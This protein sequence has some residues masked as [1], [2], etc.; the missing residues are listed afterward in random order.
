M[1][2]QTSHD[3][4]ANFRPK[5]FRCPHTMSWSQALH[6]LSL[7]SSRSS[8][9]SETLTPYSNNH[10]LQF[11]LRMNS[12]LLTSYGDL[13]HLKDIREIDDATFNDFLLQ[14]FNKFTSNINAFFNDQSEYILTGHG[15][16]FNHS[17]INYFTY[18][19][20]DLVRHIF[21]FFDT[22]ECVDFCYTSKMVYAQCLSFIWKYISIPRHQPKF[23]NQVMI[24][25]RWSC[26]E[27][28]QQWW[29]HLD[30]TKSAKIELCCPKHSKCILLTASR[31][32]NLKELEVRL[33]DCSSQDWK[34]LVPTF[35][36]FLNS[37]SLTTLKLVF[38]G[39]VSQ[40]KTHSQGL[41]E[42]G[43]NCSR[44]P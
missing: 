4:A 2:S 37:L 38:A 21:G 40:L 15:Y 43:I 36:N 22:K 16:R 39:K 34:N 20:D 41:M 5:K 23:I 6:S 33:L 24:G 32:M 14:V 19:G 27:N 13:K 30:L 29:F 31:A 1:S 9:Q 17:R 7:V 12:V 11:C 10:I 18:L 26:Y 35:L 25:D 8:L 3:W 44:F 28:G 42:G